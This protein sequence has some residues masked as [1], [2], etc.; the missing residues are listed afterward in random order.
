MAKDKDNIDNMLDRAHR[1]ALEEGAAA[2]SGEVPLEE[3]SEEAKDAIQAIE[4][5]RKYA[6][7][8]DDDEVG[9]LTFKS[10]LGGDFLRSKFVIKQIAFM[11]FCVLLALGYTFNRFDSQQDVIL[12]DSLRTEL[13]NVKYNVLTQSSELMNMIRQ[14]NIE[15]QLRLTKDSLL[16]NSVTPPYLI[17]VGEEGEKAAEVDIREVMVDSAQTGVS[18][19]NGEE[20]ENEEG[21]EN[22]AA[23][24]SQPEAATSKPESEK[25]ARGETEASSEGEKASP[26]SRGVKPESEQAKPEGEQPN[27]H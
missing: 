2:S 19:S 17:R 25:A 5:M 22:K 21:G 9:E 7:E 6:D 4:A 15:K 24:A 3:R 18:E 10:I 27:T 12:I 23:S 20:E 1:A 16:H 11:M 26:K 8:D 14:S 13:Q